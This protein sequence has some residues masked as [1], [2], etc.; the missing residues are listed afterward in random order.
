MFPECSLSLPHPV[1]ICGGL[2]DAWLAEWGYRCLFRAKHSIVTYSQ[3]SL[4][5]TV[6]NSISGQE[7]GSGTHVQQIFRGHLT[8]QYDCDSVSVSWESRAC[9]SGSGFNLIL[10]FLISWEEKGLF[11]LHFHVALNC[12]GNQDRNSDMA[13]TW[14]QELMKRSWSGATS[15]LAPL[16]YSACFLSTTSP[17]WAGPS[18]IDH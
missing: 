1:C 3:H 17:Q 9:F 4:L 18:P 12:W 11:S 14:R 15:W 10:F 13:G 16:A 2:G 5:T 6:E 8:R 7:S